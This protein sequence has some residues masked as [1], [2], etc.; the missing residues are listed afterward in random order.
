MGTISLK[1]TN[2]KTSNSLEFPLKAQ[3]NTIPLP[4]SSNELQSYATQAGQFSH[5]SGVKKVSA[6]VN[7]YVVLIQP[8]ALH[9]I[10]AVA[11][12]DAHKTNRMHV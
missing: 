7:A 5:P 9:S 11:N 3:L 1:I 10:M 2:A 12:N 6:Y 4:D 8:T